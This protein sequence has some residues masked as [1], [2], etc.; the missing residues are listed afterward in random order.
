VNKSAATS[1][2]QCWARNSF[3]VVFFF[4]SGAGPVSVQ[5]VGNRAACHLVSQIRECALDTP[6]AP[7]P[8]FFGHA[9]HQ[10]FDLSRRPWSSWSAMATAI[11]FLRDQFPM[12]G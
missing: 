1:S 7:I 2:S 8:V 5:Y 10:R 6:I 4:R 3:Q 12:P 9:Q 11:V